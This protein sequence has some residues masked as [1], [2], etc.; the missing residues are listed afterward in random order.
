MKLIL[1]NPWMTTLRYG[2]L[3]AA[4]IAVWLGCGLSALA[5]SD[6]SKDALAPK[7][8]VEDALTGPLHTVTVS[9]NSLEESLFFYRDGLGLNVEGPLS[10]TPQQREAQRRQWGVDEDVDWSVY[11]LYRDG[12]EGVAQI[13]LLVLDR[14]MPAIHQS[15]SSLELGTF[16]MG[17][18][19]LDQTELDKKVR[20]LGFGA[21]NVIERYT[22]PR[23]DGTQYPIEETIFNGPDFVHAVGINRGDGM[24]QLGPIDAATGYGGPAYSAAV[25]PDSDAMLSFLVDVLGLELRSDRVWESAGSEGALN[26]PDGTVFRFSIVYSPGSRSQHLLL[27]DYQNVDAIDTGVAPRVPHRGIGMWSFTVRDLNEVLQ[28]AQTA[29]ATL[30]SGAACFDSPVLGLVR[31]ATLQAPNGLLVELFEDSPT[32]TSPPAE[33][34]AATKRDFIIG[35]WREIVASV[36]SLAEQESVFTE[37]A[38]WSVQARSDTSAA[39]LAAWGLAPTV[40]AQ[41]V[42]IHNPGTETGFLRLLQF[43]GVEQK[44]I[45]AS[46]QSWDSGGLFDFNVRVKNMQSKHAQLQRRGWQ[47]AAEPQRFVF[48]PFE[49]SEW[50]ARGPDGIAMAMIERH[51]PPLEGWPN[52]REMSRTFNATQVV[53]DM[54]ASLRFYR[55]TLGFKPY[56][57]HRGVS[58]GE[59]DNVLG[60]PLNL[61]RELEREVWILHPDGTNEGS[62]ELL[63]FSG[64][65]G[66]DLSARAVPPNLGLLMMRFPVTN[67]EALASHLRQS[68]YALEYDVT[69]VPLPPYGEVSMFAVRA[70]NGS[71]LEFFEPT[72]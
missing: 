37:V 15:W 4:A 18:P 46:A 62:V 6:A 17:F 48:G 13:R 23:T 22:V 35:G 32:C 25:V 34:P 57:E 3:S 52:L 2:C 24:A 1:C 68:G 29:G 53:D 44:Q 41:E 7:T 72:E 30:V 70:P 71:W 67:I 56:M 64:L 47:A 36:S 16:S 5:E 60:L 54:P 8:R 65:Q 66:R 59:G 12:L 11:R 26:V 43:A 49:V 9:T 10:L 42:L 20:A 45:R 21:L 39:Q 33:S 14:P 38:G 55:D 51:E 40:S 58:Q 50:I 27:V 19:N 31:A 69:R 28:R 63:A 61:A